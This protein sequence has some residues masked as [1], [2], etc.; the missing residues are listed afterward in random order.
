[1]TSPVR[2]ATTLTRTPIRRFSD[3]GSVP[4]DGGGARGLT[5]EVVLQFAPPDGPCITGAWEDE[6]IATRKWSAL[7][8]SHGSHPTVVIDLIDVGADGRR[9][10]VRSWTHGKVQ[11]S[12]A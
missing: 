2:L 5:W 7:V 8:G 12:W 6:S 11:G 9:S 10:L 1:M 3:V 4:Q